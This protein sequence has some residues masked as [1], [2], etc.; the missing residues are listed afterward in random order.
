MTA[1]KESSENEAKPNT[2]EPTVKTK[3]RSA[4]CTKRSKNLKELPSLLKKRVDPPVLPAVLKRLGVELDDWKKFPKIGSIVRN[5][6]GSFAAAIAA[7]EADDTEDA[8]AVIEAWYSVSAFDR[9]K[10]GLEGIALAAGLT[11]RRFIEVLSGAIVQQAQ[12]VSRLMLASAQPK[13]TKTTIRRATQRSP[14][15]DREG[16]LLGYEEGDFKAME[17]FHKITGAIPTPK[18]A[19]NVFNIGTQIGNDEPAQ[20]GDGG[21]EPAELQTMDAML[22]E[23]QD[24]IRPKALVASVPS[25]NEVPINAPEV[26]YLGMDV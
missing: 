21:D 17:M 1:M 26:E 14:I 24:I 3:R 2:S 23:M 13:V 6:C 5:G 18:G 22:M 15:M 20:L 19:T 11:G 16:N 4:K 8:R 7:L 10:A 9:K 12:D 25:I